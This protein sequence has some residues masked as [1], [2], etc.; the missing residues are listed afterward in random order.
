[1]TQKEEKE[2]FII[3]IMTPFISQESSWRVFKPVSIFVRDQAE[4]GAKFSGNFFFKGKAEELNYKIIGASKV[5]CDPSCPGN[6]KKGE[7]QR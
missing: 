5:R 2:I 4:N 1:M 7:K 3:K 6:R